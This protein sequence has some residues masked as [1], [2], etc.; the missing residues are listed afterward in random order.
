M[1]KFALIENGI[2]NQIGESKPVFNNANV[3][4]AFGTWGGAVIRIDITIDGE[5]WCECRY[6]DF[7]TAE[8]TETVCYLTGHPF[9]SNISIRVRIV[10]GDAT[11]NLTVIM[12]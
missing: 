9:T 6:E 3:L 7:T 2:A 8:L 4:L 11:T 5:N 1:A 10:G 12:T